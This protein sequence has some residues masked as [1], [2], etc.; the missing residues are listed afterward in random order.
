M[1]RATVAIGA[2]AAALVVLAAPASAPAAVTDETQIAGI[3]G[4][5]GIQADGQTSGAAISASGRYVTFESRG[6]RCPNSGNPC[7]DGDDGYRINP[8]QDTSP[9]QPHSCDPNVTPP[10]TCVGVSDIFRRDMDTGETIWVST[11]SGGLDAMSPS[12]SDNGCRISYWTEAEIDFDDGND[13]GDVYVAD[14]CDSPGDVI[15]MLGSTDDGPQYAVGQVDETSGI[16]GDGEVVSFSTRNSVINEQGFNGPAGVDQVFNHRLD[17]AQTRMISVNAA[18]TGAAN[19][20]TGVAGKTATSQDG[21]RV[22]FASIATNL[23]NAEEHPGAPGCQ[24]LYD[25]RP[26]SDAGSCD[27]FVR[28]DN[29]GNTAYIPRPPHLNSSYLVD[30]DLSISGDGRKVGLTA[31]Y[32]AP[33]PD[34]HVYVRGIDDGQ[35]TFVSCT[36]GPCGVTEGGFNGL[37]DPADSQSA[38]PTLS[39]DGRF[40]SFA[41]FAG[42][43]IFP[44][45]KPGATFATAGMFIRDTVNKTTFLY[46]RAPGVTGAPSISPGEFDGQIARGGTAVTFQSTARLDPRDTNND[47][48]VYRRVIKDATTGEPDQ[49]AARGTTVDV[50]PIVIGKPIT[51]TLPGGQTVPVEHMDEYPIGTRIDATNSRVELTNANDTFGTNSMQFYEGKFTITQPRPGAGNDFTTLR[52]VDKLR[53]GGKKKGKKK[54]KG[55]L[56]VTAARR[57]RSLWG[58]GRGR[59][60]TRGKGGTASV[61]GTNWFT[62]DNCRGTLFRL[63]SGGPLQVDDFK[64]KGRVNKTLKK[65]G[66][67][68]FARDKKKKKRKK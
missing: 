13:S 54:G 63:A 9:G 48:D 67:K 53:C 3:H 50:R 66:S 60:R 55:R 27:V 33:N 57:S 35:W 32:S 44:P 5:A 21:S 22:A 10:P 25:G 8:A 68:Y 49:P 30:R 64:K 24:Y 23:G 1:R 42:N 46:S 36:S 58:N 11:E 34:K 7:G 59:Y 20:H 15:T 51:A 29:S 41:S 45:Y 31:G 6:W 62:R 43:L 56:A 40:V 47:L 19:G 16:S 18:G 65:P 26:Y 14:L 4:P 12:I 52:L 39:H 38:N 28:D 17:A 61:V 37:A 2:C